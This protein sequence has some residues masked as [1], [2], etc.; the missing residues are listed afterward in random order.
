M[1]EKD[2]KTKQD[3]WRAKNPWFKYWQHARRRCQ[4][5]KHAYFHRY[6]GRGIKFNLLLNDVKYLWLRDLA[7]NMREP[8]LGRIDSDGDYNIYN[9]AFEELMENKRK[10]LW[11]KAGYKT[12]YENF[13]HR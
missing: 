6:G 9:C 5:P 7:S 4:D 2:P 8:S 11:S 1:S 13:Y 10:M 3:R 12:D